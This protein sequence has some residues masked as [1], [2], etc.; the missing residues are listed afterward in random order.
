MGEA[1]GKTHNGMDEE[2]VK[3]R[4]VRDGKFP[5]ENM[6]KGKGEEEEE[7]RRRR[8]VEGRGIYRMRSKVKVVDGS[9]GPSGSPEY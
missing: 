7:R 6:R 8:M 4:E 2:S 9:P 5:R 1:E 3:F